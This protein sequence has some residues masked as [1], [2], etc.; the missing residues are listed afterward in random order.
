MKEEAIK[1]KTK[2]AEKAA[3]QQ[4]NKSKGG[5]FDLMKGISDVA[6]GISDAATQSARTIADSA[7]LTWNWATGE[8]KKRQEQLLKAGRDRYQRIKQLAEQAD[9]AT[10]EED[11]QRALEGMNSIR[12]LGDKASREYKEYMKCLRLFLQL[13]RKFESILKTAS[14]NPRSRC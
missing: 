12:K 2:E 13:L 10:N 14:A 11:R 8:E 6:K 5:G 3:Q 9:K 1:A 7:A 4:G